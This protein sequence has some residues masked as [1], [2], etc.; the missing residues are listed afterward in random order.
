MH[1]VTQI[2]G[3]LNVTPDSFSDGGHFVNPE[4]AYSHARFLA[5]NGA[6]IVDI[7]AESTR[8][9]SKPVDETE[10]WSRLKPVL[11]LLKRRPLNARI[12][13]DTQKPEIMKKSVQYGVDV[14]NDVSG[15]ADDST[16]KFLASENVTYI[17]MHKYGDTASM[18]KNPLQARQALDAMES[19]YEKTYDR[20]LSMG[21]TKELIWLDPGIGF[22][23]TD[24]ANIQLLDQ[25][26]D[27]CDR[28][29]IV[30][31]ISRKSFI[32]RVLDIENATDRDTPSK[33]LE[34]GLMFSGARAIRTHE[35]KALHK[36]K[37]L[38]YSDD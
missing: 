15:G 4:Q 29:N 17:C 18:Q 25:A 14:I 2:M 35:V 10:E 24:A 8:P 37:S 5:E 11:E 31:G 23:K 27:F 38:L 6:D 22:G 9:G 33:M 26:C 21:F 7:G 12:S 13:I 16:L 32:G 1:T 19:F 34:L 30:L 3:I 36:L 20:L 28:Y